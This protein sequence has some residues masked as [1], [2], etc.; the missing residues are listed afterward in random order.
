MVVPKAVRDALQLPAGVELTVEVGDGYFVVRPRS[1]I[2]PTTIDEVS[3]MFKVDR[4]ITDEE[5]ERGIEA[6]YRA[7]WLRKR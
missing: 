4:P 5:I 2:R 3:G 7:R 6:G 1:R